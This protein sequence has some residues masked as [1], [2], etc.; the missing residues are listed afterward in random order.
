MVLQ[1]SG[2]AVLSGTGQIVNSFVYITLNSVGAIPTGSQ[3]YGTDVLSPS[4]LVYYASV[5][6]AEPASPNTPSSIVLWSGPT[7]G[8]GFSI[9]GSSFNFNTAVPGNP[10]VIFAPVSA[11]SIQLAAGTASHSFTSVFA[12]APVV[13]VTSSNTTGETFKVSATGS[14]LTITSSN[15]SSTAIVNWIAT[16][17]AN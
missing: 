13:V 17:A 4:G 7:G 15:V 2:A 10:G 1:L 14:G 3:V 11:G 16:A 6:L 8:Q 12:T 5:R 9:T